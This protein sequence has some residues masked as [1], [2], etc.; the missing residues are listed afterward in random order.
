MSKTTV[1]I[2]P[3]K[4]SQAQRVLDTR[5]IKDTIEA[6][7]EQV[8]ARAARQEF[9]DVAAEGMFAELL[10]RDAERRMWD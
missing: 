10:E 8:V 9:V 4:L 2:D 7:F 1:E 5:T 3:E 6:A